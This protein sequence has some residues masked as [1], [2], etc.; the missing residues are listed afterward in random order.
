MSLLHD[1]PRPDGDVLHD[2]VERLQN[3]SRYNDVR[4]GVAVDHDVV[5]L[6]GEVR[7]LAV[8]RH[9]EHLVQKVPGVVA[10]ASEVIAVRPEARLRNDFDLARSAARVLRAEPHLPYENLEVTVSR[11]VVTLE[12]AVDWPYQRAQIVRA[13]AELPGVERVEDRIHL[14]ERV[15]RHDVRKG[16]EGTLQRQAARI[17]RGIRIELDDN[18][19]TVTG[20]VRTAKEK[21]DVERAAWQVKGVLDVRNRLEV[22]A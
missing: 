22:Q 21:D 20:S 13:I 8:K 9:V 12:G 3:D 5:T 7:S 15:S 19:V 16:I 6:T 1:V 17:A 10:V 4:V 14:T 18:R 11:G 2:V